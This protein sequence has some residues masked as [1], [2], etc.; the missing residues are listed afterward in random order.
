[1]TKK[2]ITTKF[3]L[4]YNPEL[5]ERAKELR[6]QMTIAEKK[7]WNDYLK[8]FPLRVL[9][10]RPIDQFIVDFYCPALK[11]VV[12][13][14]GE[15]HFTDE[16]Q[17]RDQVRTHILEGYGLTVMRFTNQQVLHKFEGVCGEIEKMIP[18]NP[19]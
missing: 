6:K 7:L 4:P 5:V 10:Q 1:M 2:L 9:R 3:H 14:D 18:L 17:V 12:E 16:A 11:L 15:S 13:V 8:A 19:P